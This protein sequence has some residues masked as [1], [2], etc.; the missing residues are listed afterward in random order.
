MWRLAELSPK[1]RG[2]VSVEDVML[3]DLGYL[4]DVTEQILLGLEEQPAWLERRKLIRRGTGHGLNVACCV[5]LGAVI[6]QVSE[7]GHSP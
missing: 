6:A 2:H 5:N 4:E 7:C 1:H 3:P